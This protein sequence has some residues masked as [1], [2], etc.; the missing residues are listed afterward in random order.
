LATCARLFGSL[1][2][3]QVRSGRAL[4][5]VLLLATAGGAYA[6]RRWQS[7]PRST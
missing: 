2:G 3:A 6:W 7:S 4:V 5:V 1:P